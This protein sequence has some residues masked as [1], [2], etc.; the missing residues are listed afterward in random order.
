MPA[1]GGEAR[2]LT[3]DDALIPSP[4]AWVRDGKSLLFS[5]ARGGLP[6]IWRI[7][8]CGGSATQ[9]LE[10]G[11]KAVHPII[12]SSGHRL[13]F[14]QGM[15]SSSLW[16]LEVDALGKKDA[17]R[18]V[19]ASRGSNRAAEFSPDGTKIVFVSNRS[20]SDE[21]YTCNA[22]GSNLLQLTSLGAARTPEH[23]RWSPDGR[24]IAFDSVLAE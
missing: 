17:R 10:A 24:K 6:T 5:S 16:N 18:Q 21:I 22:D 9:V 11:V 8:A 15:G 13:A 2:R 12:P 19:T 7:P 1:N 14:E 23:P 4:P 20:G 3:F